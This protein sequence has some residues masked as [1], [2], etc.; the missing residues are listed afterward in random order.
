MGR[1]FHRVIIALIFLSLNALL[2]AGVY[3]AFIKAPETCSDGKRNQDEQGIDCGG[4]CQVACIEEVVGKD[5]QVQEVTFVSGGSGS[6]DI[7]GRFLNPNSAIGASEFRYTFEL[8][9]ANGQVLSTRSGKNYAL[10]QETKNIIELNMETGGLPVRATLTMSDVV[11]EKASGYREKPAVNIYQKRY[12]PTTS[13]FGFSRAS[14]LLSN[15]SSYDF[16]SIDVGVILRDASGRLLALNK[17]RQNNIKAGESR[18]F[19]LVWPLP[20]P[21]VVEQVDMEVDADVYHSENFSKQYFP[22]GSAR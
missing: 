16:R 9:D 20:F 11:W 1:M 21:G 19:D 6:Y 15:E 8:K 2:I 3:F 5:L 4:V 17:T 22:G 7:L 12:G 14:G 18:D 13:G 10:P